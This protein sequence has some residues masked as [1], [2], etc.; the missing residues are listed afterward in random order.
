M[1]LDDGF[2]TGTTYSA[3]KKISEEIKSDLLRSGLVPKA[4]K[5]LWEPVQEIE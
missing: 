1:F 3:T 4:G 5:S 2:A